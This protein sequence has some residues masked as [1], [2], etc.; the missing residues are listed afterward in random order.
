LFSVAITSWA[1]NI[2]GKIIIAI[3]LFSFL[4]VNIFS[5]RNYII[6]GIDG[7]TTIALGNQLQAIDWVYKNANGERFNV[8]VYVPPVIPYAYNYL[9]NWYGEKTYGYIPDEERISL[10]Y[11]LSE[12]D[13]PHPERLE[14]WQLRQNG[15]GKVLGSNSFGGITVE[16][17]IRIPNFNY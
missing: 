6:S 13:S 17:R 7:P 10:L 16:K 2:F 5:V 14:A 15:I 4:N 8:D 3:F 1:N 11:T 9:F 12:V